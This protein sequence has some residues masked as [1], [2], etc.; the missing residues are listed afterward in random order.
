MSRPPSD[1]E[2]IM[3]ALSIV[4]LDVGLRQEAA[5]PHL[6]KAASTIAGELHERC[7]VLRDERG[8]PRRG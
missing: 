2:L 8:A 3:T 5:H 7:E 4:M 1:N 6:S